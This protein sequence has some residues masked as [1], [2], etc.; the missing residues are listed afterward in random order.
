MPGT[1]E[2]HTG[3]RGLLVRETSGAGGASNTA[4][5]VGGA[6]VETKGR[7]KRWAKTWISA[8]MVDGSSRR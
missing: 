4:S 2:E 5:A 3:F 7:P 8:G 6:G 1:R